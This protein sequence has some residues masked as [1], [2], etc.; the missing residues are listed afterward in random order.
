M[1]QK[2]TKWVSFETL[3]KISTQLATGLEELTGKP[4]DPTR[5]YMSE[6]SAAKR[7]W[8]YNTRVLNNRPSSPEFIPGERVEGDENGWLALREDEVNFLVWQSGENGCRLV[9]RI[10]YD[11]KDWQL[12]FI[13][14]DRFPN[15]R[16]LYWNLFKQ[17][18]DLAEEEVINAHPRHEPLTR[19]T[20]WKG[21]GWKKPLRFA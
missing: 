21:D 2:Y 12:E 11:P 14:S 1:A 9:A 4:I 16:G 15:Y 10:G 5:V 8:M 19:R 3:S 7:L 6:Q 18:Q 17:A 13:P 20:V